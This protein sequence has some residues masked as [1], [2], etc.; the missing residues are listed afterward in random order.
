MLLKY[1]PAVFAV[2]T[3]YL[4]MVPVTADC[5]FS[6]KIGD[7]VYH[8]AISGVLRSKVCVHRVKVPQREL[9]AVGAYTVC[10]RPMVERLPY[11][12]VTGEPEEYT[13][14][15]SPVPD[16]DVRIYHLADCHTYVPEPLAAAA[17]F[18]NIDLLILN[19]D[20]F[21]DADA[22]IMFERIYILCEQLTGGHIPVVCARGN[23]DLRGAFAEDYT[24][25]MPADGDNTFYTF[26]VGK[27][28]GVVLDAG[29]DKAD[30]APTYRH[31]VCCTGFRKQQTAFLQRV[32]DEA[33][34]E[35]A[36]P[37]VVTRLVVCHI[38]FTELF[39][40]PCDIEQ[41]T[42]AAW[43]Q[44]LAEHIRPDLMLCGHT[45]RL[46]VKKEATPCPLMIG[47]AFGE[48]YVAGCGLVLQEKGCAV[49][50]TDSCGDVLEAEYIPFERG[51][52]K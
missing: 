17:V 34:T 3:D 7:K 23:H 31:T 14:A 22:E 36:T 48:H 28:W 26:R 6:V 32:I 1:T 4:I 5:L 8:D 25:W 41:E 21:G 2:G 30:D 9:D 16:T 43:A 11:D 44:L 38:P 12:S 37:D 24:D 33:P 27:I 39:S 51:E 52:L 18:G 19:G 40:P 20:A 45:H 42:Y 47:S 13:Y 10:V 50:F 46:A 15:F 49:M 29:E 35:Y